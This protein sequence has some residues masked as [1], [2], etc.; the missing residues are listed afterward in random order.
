MREEQDGIGFG[1]WGFKLMIEK[2][3]FAS[4]CSG[5]YRAKAME[6]GFYDLLS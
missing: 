1:D 5:G 3:L 6:G 2:E 4:C